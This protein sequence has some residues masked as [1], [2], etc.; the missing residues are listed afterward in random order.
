LPIPFTIEKLRN[1][2]IKFRQFCICGIGKILF[3]LW[4]NVKEN[5][6]KQKFLESRR[7][8]FPKDAKQFFY[9]TKLGRNYGRN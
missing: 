8:P 2:E 7:V 6:T 3:G 1:A 5:E 9:L 4:K